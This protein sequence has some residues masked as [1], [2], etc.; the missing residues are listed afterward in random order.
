M[1]T[2]G[3]QKFILSI[4]LTLALGVG[5]VISATLQP[6]YPRREFQYSFEEAGFVP[7]PVWTGFGE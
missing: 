5:W 7:G 2:E 6:L 1:K 3:E 4:S